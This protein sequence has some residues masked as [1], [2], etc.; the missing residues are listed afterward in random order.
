MELGRGMSNAIHS[1][2]DPGKLA[3]LEIMFKSQ[4]I[5]NDDLDFPY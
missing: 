1:S 4:D 5:L 3:G 2:R